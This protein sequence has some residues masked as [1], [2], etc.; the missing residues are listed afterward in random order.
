MD[1]A[2][3]AYNHGRLSDVSLLSLGGDG[4]A[5]RWIELAPMHH[6][7]RQHGIALFAGRIFVVDSKSVEMLTP[8]RAV[9]DLGQWTDL[10]SINVAIPY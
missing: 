5:P 4:D 8:L 9:G 7:R 3:I 1:C 2:S 10:N 6:A